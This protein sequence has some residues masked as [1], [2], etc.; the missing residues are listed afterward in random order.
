ML[1]L[2]RQPAVRLAMHRIPRRQF[3]GFIKGSEDEQGS[4]IPGGKQEEEARQKWA[5]NN[6]DRMVSHSTCNG[7]L[8]QLTVG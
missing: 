5:P 3:R 1:R 2:F 6:Y 8:A 4:F 7:L